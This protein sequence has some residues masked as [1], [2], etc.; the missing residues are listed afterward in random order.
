MVL[1]RYRVAWNISK[2]ASKQGQKFSKNPEKEV[3]RVL[4][5][6]FK[7]NRKGTSRYGY[8]AETHINNKNKVRIK[9]EL[10]DAIK[11][12]QYNSFDSKTSIQYNP[13]SY[14]HQNDISNTPLMCI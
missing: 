1:C 5:F 12:I 11:R 13:K 2:I 14:G 10:R 8:V 4:G 6:Y 7:A 3:N 9:S